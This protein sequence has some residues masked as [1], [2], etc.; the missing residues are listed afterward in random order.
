MFKAFSAGYYRGE[1]VV[2][3]FDEGPAIESELYEYIRGR[4]YNKTETDVMMQLSLSCSPKFCPKAENAMPAEVLGLPKQMLSS[5]RG[6]S[7]GDKTNVYIVRPL[8]AEIFSL[9]VKP[10]W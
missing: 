5:G 3:R 6:L 7:P 1:M 8:Y 2:E 4:L 10:S 9:E